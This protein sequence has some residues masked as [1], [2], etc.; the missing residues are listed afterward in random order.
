MSLFDVI[1]YPISDPPTKEELAAIPNEIFD[2]W[3]QDNFGYS[4]PLKESLRQRIIKFYA[5]DVHT[6][7]FNK[8]ELRVL[9][10]IIKD[11][12]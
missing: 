11:L 5:R 8:D 4:P 2:N 6:P 3:V 1:K 9:R 7:S 10:Q 12:P